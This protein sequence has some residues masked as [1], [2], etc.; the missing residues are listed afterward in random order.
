MTSFS[1]ANPIVCRDLRFSRH[2]LERM[3]ERGIA[4]DAVEQIV[5]GGKVIASYPDDRP[6]P[7]FLLMGAHDGHAVHVVVAWNAL[8][9]LCQVVTVYRPDPGLWN[10]TFTS[11]KQP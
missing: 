9:G 8:D 1:D 3:F 2:A 10:A 11:R 6:Y 4:P 7:S 5:T